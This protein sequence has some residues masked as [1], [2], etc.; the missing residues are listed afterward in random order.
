MSDRHDSE[1]VLSPEQ[2]EM[3]KRAL[4]ETVDYIEL[5][6]VAQLESDHAF[7]EVRAILPAHVK[8]YL[9]E[10]YKGGYIHA[11]TKLKRSWDD[12]RTAVLERA[13]HVGLLAAQAALAI[14]IFSSLKESGAGVLPGGTVHV[15]PARRPIVDVDIAEKAAA[16]IDCSV[17]RGTVKITW[18]WCS[19]PA[20]RTKSIVD[21]LRADLF[22]G[23]KRE[24]ERADSCHGGPD[25]V[26]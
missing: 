26:D 1:V 12:D 5:S 3:L 22:G 4:T 25:I 15:R 17:N 11:I 16:C 18:E 19:G 23:S 9:I 10:R 24:G 2:E 21:A 8:R 13:R 7:T 20:Q 6:A 14:S